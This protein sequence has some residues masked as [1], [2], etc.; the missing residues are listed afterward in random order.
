MEES[1]IN[2]GE[3]FYENIEAP[4]FVDFTVP[5][6][7]RPDDRYWFCLRVGCDQKHEEELDPEEIYKNFV[8]RVMAARSPNIRL[9]KALNRKPPSSSL[10]C[11]LTAPAKP[12]KSRISRL[13]I[14]SSLSRKM[15]DVKDK[16]R[17]LSKVSATP[18]AN[19]KQ[20]SVAAKALTTPRKRERI[21]NPDTFKSVRNPKETKLEVPKNRVIAKA[22]VF[23]SPR[24]VVCRLKTSVELKTP[25]RKLCSAMKKLEINGGTKQALGCH[26]PLPSNTSRKQFRGREVK[27]R[28]YDSLHSHTNKGHKAKPLKNK[29]KRERD[30]KQ[31]CVP[32]DD[33]ND[34]KRHGSLEGSSAS[35]ASKNGEAKSSEVE[36]VE[37]TVEVLSEIS[38]EETTTLSSSED[39]DSG[40]GNEECLKTVKFSEAEL[41]EHPVEVL[42]ETSREEI[43]SLSSSEERY[44]GDGDAN[45]LDTNNHEER[46]KLSSDKRSNPDDKENAL[47]SDHANAVEVIES[48]DKENA[49]PSDLA[50]AGE[51]KENALPSDHANAGEVIESEDKENASASDGNREHNNHCEGKILSNHDTSKDSKKVNQ[52]VKKTLKQEAKYKKPKPT[53]P[54]PFRF[55]T[56]ER[57]ILKEAHLEKKLTPLK[58]ITSEKLPVKKSS[59]NHQNV[60]QKNGSNQGKSENEN[61]T[62][63]DREKRRDRTPADHPGKT[64]S[65]SSRTLKG[66]LEQ[67]LPTKTPRRRA[68]SGKSH[69]ENQIKVQKSDTMEKT[70]SPS[71]RRK[72]LRPQGITSIKKTTQTPGQLG[73][74]KET[75]PTILRH[76]EAAKP[77]ENGASPATQTSDPITSRSV[78]RGR[79]TI[80]IP[81]EPN[82]H[83]IHIPKSCTKKVV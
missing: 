51:D 11:P 82:F 67:K 71:I 43:T 72:I 7:Y 15:G 83:S 1:Q 40:N 77:G 61:A 56:D 42:S 41:G 3:E 26:K 2:G 20:S 45:V 79:R 63:E 52:V 74:I 14:I 24:K 48:E 50:N 4:K 13:D 80:T 78:S 5:D 49:L 58:E 73:V 8:L 35:D 12:S 27:S 32:K 53:N 66:D 19:L 47:P 28:V 22:L 81:K 36:S 18:K 17:T 38:R 37:H 59:T 9:R 34:S 30:L 16:T 25:V 44:S 55:R 46:I 65:T 62:Q 57:G 39:R 31:S 76:R 21:L 75:S 64:R 23:H 54:K 29:E 68:I 6:Q 10:K 33:E 70:K 69:K 60:N